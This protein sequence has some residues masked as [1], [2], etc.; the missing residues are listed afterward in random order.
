MIDLVEHTRTS[1]FDRFPLP[2]LT[3]F[4]I[5]IWWNHCCTLFFQGPSLRVKPDGIIWHISKHE[6]GNCMKKLR[7]CVIHQS[8]IQLDLVNLAST[9]IL[10]NLW[11]WFEQK[12]LHESGIL[13]PFW[14]G[15][16]NCPFI[17][18]LI[19]CAMSLMPKK[20]HQVPKGHHP[21]PLCHA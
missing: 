10:G 7:N 21:Y 12:N 20:K 6:N 9:W 4:V 16:S 11:A 15:P 14:R 18:P 2:C 5:S 13:S 19:L 3:Q 17:I 8:S 1:K